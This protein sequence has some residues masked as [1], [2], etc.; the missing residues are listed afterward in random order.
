MTKSGFSLVWQPTENSANSSVVKFP[1]ERRN[2][3]ELLLEL[4]LF[5]KVFL[6][7]KDVVKLTG[8][9]SL[10]QVI[11]NYCY[12]ITYLSDVLIVNCYEICLTF[13]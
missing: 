3:K 5:D 13:A 1:F 7:K 12:S 10:E 9:V 2:P 6:Q 11:S 4:E 8:L